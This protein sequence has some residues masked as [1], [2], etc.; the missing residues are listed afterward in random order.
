M[1]DVNIFPEPKPRKTFKS[2]EW[3]PAQGGASKISE[4]DFNIVMGTLPD[5]APITSENA[6]RL[7]I[8]GE[9]DKK[10]GYAVR[11]LGARVSTKL[12]KVNFALAEY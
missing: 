9:R 10:L 6:R 5:V 8:V 11:E 7:I 4:R 12:Y 3:Q 1:D 2:L